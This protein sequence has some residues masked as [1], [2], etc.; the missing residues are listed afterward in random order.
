MV[1]FLFSDKPCKKDSDCDNS[2]C[3]Y[4]KSDGYCRGYAKEYCDNFPCGVG[5]GDCDRRTCISGLTCGKNNFLEY[6]PLL[7]HCMG[8]Y[9]KNAEV[10]IEKGIY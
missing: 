7:P 6:H 2:N 8:G 3:E 9:I 1:A 4:C 5:D 10:C